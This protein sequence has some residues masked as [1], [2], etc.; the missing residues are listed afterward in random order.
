VIAGIDGRIA[1][2]DA[3][4]KQLAVS[5]LWGDFAVVQSTC[6]GAK[7]AAS[8]HGTHLASDSI[9]LY[10]LVNHAPSRA[11]DETEVPGPVTAMWPA[12]STALAVVRN[13]NT[14]R[15]EAYSIG[16]DCGR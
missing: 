3:A 11:S 7:I 2:Y 4:R 13:K 5:D 14:E 6:A 10:E 8:A 16:V 9:A 12:G 1:V 15:Y